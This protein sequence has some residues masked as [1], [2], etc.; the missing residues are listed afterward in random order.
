MAFPVVLPALGDIGLILSGFCLSVVFHPG[1]RSAVELNFGPADRAGVVKRLLW[2][3]TAV[4][5]Y[6]YLGLTETT[7]LICHL[8]HLN[9]DSIN[10]LRSTG[11]AI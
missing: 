8:N 7:L 1:L 3:K 2:S 10:S 6:M 5:S 9:K 4:V 11:F